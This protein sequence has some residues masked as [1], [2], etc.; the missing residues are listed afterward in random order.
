MV[1]IKAFKGYVPKQEIGE[2]LISHP[3]D[4]LNT[5]EARALAS[6]NE[7][8][9]LHV[10]KPEIDLNPA[11]GYS[12]E[13]YSAGHSALKRFIGWLVREAAEMVCIYNGWEDSV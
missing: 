8:S 4:V 7:H 6:G 10:N 2:R 5:E 1:K 9:F 13:D 3:Y 11:T 12:F